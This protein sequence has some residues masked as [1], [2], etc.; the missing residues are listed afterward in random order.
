MLAVFDNLDRA[1]AAAQQAGDQGPLAVGVTMTHYLL[2]E[3]LKRHGIVPIDAVG[4][5]FDPARHDAVKSQP[6][7]GVPP[8]TV[9]GLVSPGYTIHDRVLRPATV[10]VSAA[11]Q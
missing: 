9:V 11:P 7:G 3:T 4:Q 1:I 2:L 10:V 5:P 6:D 8:N